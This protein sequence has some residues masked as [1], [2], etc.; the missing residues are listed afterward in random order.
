MIGISQP[1]MHNVLN[2]VRN[3]SIDISDSIL[4]IFHITILDLAMAEEMEINLQLR[5]A[6][7]PISELPFLDAPIG[8][9]IAQPAGIGRLRFAPPFSALSRAPTLMMARLALDPQMD[10]TLA[11]YDIAL[12]DTSERQR[13][14]PSPEGLYAVERAG[15]LVL[16]YMRP[17]ARGYYLVTDSSLESPEQWERLRVA[18]Q[19]L[20][21][22]IKGRVLWL[23]REKDREL[24]M[25]QR[26]RF[27]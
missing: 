13:T 24:P 5:K 12:L 7:D 19:D 11:P 2:G 17:G 18:P 26:G 16:R 4:K 25:G 21:E 9:R 15:E 6:L 3:L 1:H 8:P 10:T 27:L 14:E 20:P 23:G 22:F